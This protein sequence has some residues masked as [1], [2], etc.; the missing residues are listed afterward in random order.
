MTKLY[1]K[2]ILLLVGVFSLFALSACSHTEMNGDFV[3]YEANGNGTYI[4][5]DST[6]YLTIDNKTY[7]GT[8]GDAETSGVIDYSAH[9]LIPDKKTD[10]TVSYSFDE[11]NKVLTIK[12]GSFSDKYVKKG[13]SYYKKI[14]NNRQ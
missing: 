3:N 12:D 9:K 5:S 8:L 11:K 2:T 7:S 4:V 10:K 1:K 6:S 13:S 14:M